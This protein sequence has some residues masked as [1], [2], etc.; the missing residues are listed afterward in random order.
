MTARLIAPPHRGVVF[1][2]TNRGTHDPWI[3]GD[4]G[5]E[6]LPWTPGPRPAPAFE[7]GCRRCPRTWRIGARRYRALHEA[8]A[9]GTLAGEVDISV[10]DL[11]SL[12]GKDGPR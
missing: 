1:Y 3:V 7:Y 6:E 10:H 8:A 11:D 12:L 5:L 2:C 9:S 4:M